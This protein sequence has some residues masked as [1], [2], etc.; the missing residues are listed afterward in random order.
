MTADAKLE[1]LIDQVAALPE[2]ERVELLQTLLEMDRRYPE[3][4]HLDDDERAALAR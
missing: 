4:Y 1:H 3:P 2:V